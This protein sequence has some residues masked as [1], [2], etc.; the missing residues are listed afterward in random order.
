MIIQNGPITRRETLRA[1]KIERLK[2]WAFV[3]IPVLGLGL[4]AIFSR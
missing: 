1:Q 4:M 2:K 3:L